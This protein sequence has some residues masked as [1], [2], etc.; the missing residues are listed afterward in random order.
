[1]SNFETERQEAPPRQSRLKLTF[2]WGIVIAIVYMFFVIGGRL[3]SGI[4]SDEKDYSATNVLYGGIIPIALAIAAIVLIGRWRGA[5][6]TVFF[7]P[8]ELRL[9]RPRWLWIMPILILAAGVTGLIVAPWREF[10]MGTLIMLVVVSIGI[11][12][13]EELAM[14]GY[15]LAG[16][17]DRFGEVGA[18]FWSTL[19]FALV[20]FAG[21]LTGT[22]FGNQIQQVFFAFL[23]GS[24]L[25]FCRRLTGSLLLP[26][27]LHAQFD[28]GNFVSNGLGEGDKASIGQPTSDDVVQFVLLNFVVTIVALIVVFRHRRRPK[29]VEA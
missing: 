24:S 20:H 28:F 7:D 3:V 14:R 10:S 1:M 6:R 18:W 27:V 11:G 19:V 17:R 26:I 16:A 29:T 9:R 23:T 2:A 15:L 22:S 4:P 5:D 8:P 12:I 25:Y 21:L 13:G